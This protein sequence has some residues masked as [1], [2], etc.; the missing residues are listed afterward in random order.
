M[1]QKAIVLY[2]HMKGMALDAIR[3]DLVETLQILSEAVSLPPALPAQSSPS[4]VPTIAR[5]SFS[6]YSRRF[7]NGRWC[8][9]FRDCSMNQTTGVVGSSVAE[10]QN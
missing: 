4:E 9:I 3:H 6:R 1:D 2:L 10:M 8:S 5:F 7:S